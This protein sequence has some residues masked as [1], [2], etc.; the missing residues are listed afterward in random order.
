MSPESSKRVGCTYPLLVLTRDLRPLLTSGKGAD[1][2]FLAGGRE[3]KAHLW[4]LAIRSPVVKGELCG[5]MTEN[6]LQRIEISDIEAPVFGALLEYIYSNTTLLPEISEGSSNSMAL[7]KGLLVVADRYGL[8]L[9]K[10][11]CEADLAKRL[12]IENVGAILALADRYHCLQLKEV[13]L[14][15]IFSS[16]KVLFRFALTEGYSQLKSSC[17]EL[18]KEIDE[19]L[20]LYVSDW[21]VCGLIQRKRK[22]KGFE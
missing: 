22:K 6:N 17:P 21:F 16:T 15:F 19:W 12:E 4:V 13:C 2:I 3:L 8:E 14:D 1:V 20:C 9:L 10:L 7:E 5:P 18:M 11:H